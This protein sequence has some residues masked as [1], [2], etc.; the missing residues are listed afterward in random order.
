MA[1]MH[2]VFD[3]Y[4]NG[5][6]GGVIEFIEQ[7][8]NGQFVLPFF[9]PVFKTLVT[10]LFLFVIFRWVARLYYRLVERQLAKN[11]Q[12]YSVR[13]P[14]TTRD[15]S[16]VDELDAAQYP[17]HTFTALIKEKA[18]GKLADLHAR[19]NQPAEAAKWYLKDK[20]PIRAADQLARAGQTHKAA[21]LLMRH[22]EYETAASFYA[23][24]SQYSKA[25]KAYTRAGK[26]AEA[27]KAWV[28]GGKAL[29]GVACFESLLTSDSFPLEE[30]ER[31]ADLCYHLIQSTGLSSSLPIARKNALYVNLARIFLAAK[32]PAL[33][34]GL[35]QEAGETALASEIYKRMNAPQARG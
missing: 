1:I 30:R 3:F 22:G 18:Y 9:A 13:E 16:F 14:Y 27:G 19:L 33:A 10:L 34:A 29:K 15:T 12:P 6:L 17:V 4:W 8:F 23:Q 35:F 25:A 24:V 32:R 2:S 26:L 31:A 21:K 11:I 28:D 7:L 20:Q 5:L